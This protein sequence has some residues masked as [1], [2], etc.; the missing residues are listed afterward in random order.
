MP[1]NL[2]SVK[3][4]RQNNVSYSKYRTI[5]MMKKQKEKNRRNKH[6]QTGILFQIKI[7]GRN[8]EVM[9]DT[10]AD[11]TL[12]G[13][14]HWEK[15]GLNK[16]LTTIGKHERLFDVNRQP[17]KLLGKFEATLESRSN[18]IKD[19]IYVM[20]KK[21]KAPPLISEDALLT[22]GY[23]RYDSQ[24]RFGREQRSGEEAPK[25]IKSVSRSDAA[26][27]DIVKEYPTVFSGKVGKLK[28]YE[29]DLKL[30]DNAVPLL[31]KAYTIPLHLEAITKK[32]LDRYVEND[33]MEWL[34]EKEYSE[35]LSFTSPLVV[36]AKP[37]S[38]DSVRTTVNFKY[39]NQYLKRHRVVEASKIEQHMTKLRGC[40]YF[41][42]LDMNDAYFQIPLS[43]KSRRLCTMTTQ[44]GMLRYKRLPMGLICSQDYFDERI[45]HVLQGIERCLVYRDDIILAAETQEEYEKTLRQVLDR[46]KKHGLTCSRKK[47]EFNLKEITWLGYRLNEHGIMPSEK[48]IRDLKAT[49]LPQTKEALNSFVCACH[50][51]ERFILRFSEQAGALHDAV[52]SEEPLIWT[53][54]LKQAFEQLK[55]ALCTDALNTYYDPDLPTGVWTDAGQKSH[56]PGNKGGIS[57]VLAQKHGEHWTPVVFASRRMTAVEGRYSQIEAESLAISYMLSHKLSYYLVGA[58]R[59][60]VFTDCKPLI[61]IY[62]GKRKN[63]PPRIQRHVL[64]VQHLDFEIQYIKGILN[65][66]DWLSRNAT[67]S[68]DNDDDEASLIRTI[69]AESTPPCGLELIKQET[70]RDPT[71]KK[72]MSCIRLGKI[73]KIEE[74]LKPFT[75][76]FDNL[77]VIDGIVYR[78]EQIIPPDSLKQKL[79]R[80]AHVVIPPKSLYKAI[81][82]DIHNIGHQGETRTKELLKTR[83]FWPNFSKDIEERVQHCRECQYATKSYRKEPRKS[84]PLP[85]RAFQCISIDH[86]GPYKGVYFL[87][88]IDLYSRW[89]DVFI[90]TSTSFRAMKKHL[91]TY[92]ANNGCPISIKSDNASGFTSQEFKKFCRE[93]G[94]LKV[95]HIVPESPWVNGEVENF[96]KII[97]RTIMRCET[98]KEPIQE[99]IQRVLLAYRNTPHPT[100]GKTPA[101]LAGRPYLRLG[102]LDHEIFKPTKTKELEGFVEKNKQKNNKRH[103][104]RKHDF[105]PGDLVLVDLGQREL[106]YQRDVYVVTAVKGSAITARRKDGKIVMRDSSKF[107]RFYPDLDLDIATLLPTTQPDPPKDDTQFDF[108]DEDNQD[109]TTPQTMTLRPRHRTTPLT[110][111]P[112]PN[113]TSNP[114]QQEEDQTPEE[115]P[116]NDDQRTQEERDE[117]PAE[118]PDQPTPAEASPQQQ[119]RDEQPQ[120]EDTTD[121]PPVIPPEPIQAPENQQQPVQ[122]P[123]RNPP[124]TVPTRSTRSQ[125]PA[126]DV[127]HVLPTAYKW[128]RDQAQKE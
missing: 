17:I 25:F 81:A 4:A 93:E 10:G 50:W 30:A 68:V 65:Q 92:F 18:K 42:R 40:K 113:S 41:A 107:K 33:L 22:L 116:A 85:E 111:N 37:N 114:K 74:D 108:G 118:P 125:G 80:K 105:V 124:Q 73:K 46:F 31:Q 28:N 63:V 44:F 11:E 126:P 38:S 100:T 51:N 2:Y 23:V 120:V 54:K 112:R 24:G 58:P 115:Q 19:T 57:A 59:F 48:K 16:K 78:G 91:L 96:N 62:S 5:K 45:T 104:V 26:P 87:S 36:V 3:V 89:P 84:E 127:P 34:T 75:G 95:R 1:H 88:I 82:K 72:L 49:Q 20:E 77:S 79:Y 15:L 60:H 61:P 8:L 43:E 14:E 66:S 55:D 12:F 117:P 64:R 35:P 119:L 27:P 97:K 106:Y 29:V 90:T 123:P 122:S 86:K 83:F 47:S 13:R 70:S 7:E 121:R 53:D 39:L 103:N 67:S 94:V 32:T 109:M 102:Q 76:I 9:P 21:M 99:E 128:F 101:E 110:P 6:P 71:L 98:N 69:K 52:H 56:V